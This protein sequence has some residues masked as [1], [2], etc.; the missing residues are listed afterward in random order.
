MKK[1]ISHYGSLRTLL[2][3]LSY[4]CY[5]KAY[6]KQHNRLSARTY[7]DNLARARFFLPKDKLHETRHHRHVISSI[8]GDTYYSSEN[9]LINSYR[10]KK[11]LPTTAFY[12]ILLLQIFAMAIHPLSL[13]ELWKHPALSRP[14]PKGM[15][16]ND[17]E[18]IGLRLDES[19]LRRSLRELE[20]LGLLSAS[21][22][23]RELTYSIPD[24]PLANLSSEEVTLLYYAIAFYK[25]AAL[26]SV[27]G[28]FLTDTLCSL[29]PTLSRKIVPCQFK[30]N[31]FSRIL[32]D[33]LIDM[34]LDAI[35]QGKNL[36]FLYHNRRTKKRPAEF[37]VRPRLIITDYLGGSRQYL[38]AL[39]H[40]VPG[41][42]LHPILFRLD[43]I[44]SV[45]LTAPFPQK[46][47]PALIDKNPHTLSLRFSFDTPFLEHRLRQA[48]LDRCPQ[49][50]L[51]PSA[52][53]SFLC[54]IEVTDIRNYYPWLRTFFP[55]VEILPISTGFTR[56]RI[57]DDIE[58]ALKNYGES[59]S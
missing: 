13:N 33:E 42:K 44:Q 24:N 23:G 15:S 18:D 11:L 34:I 25:N 27:P 14:L 52:K 36:R 26:L 30:D 45:R 40:A 20:E 22:R 59:I 47:P 35:Q 48:V 3:F 55:Y 41:E 29:Y 1:Y 19:T 54:T 17:A 50:C 7:E 21:K 6:F 28:Y 5:H 49:A 31:S 12:Y 46:A 37:I 2:Q 4:G 9:Y 56:Q 51:A 58:E 57:A 39:G 53:N 32:D 38:A 43:R 10:V 8:R 16:S